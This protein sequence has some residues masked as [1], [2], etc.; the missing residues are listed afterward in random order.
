MDPA[1][2]RAA[3]ALQRLPFSRPWSIERFIADLG[4]QLGRLIKVEELPRAISERGEISGL[5][6]PTDLVDVVLVKQGAAG[7]YR[8]HIICHEIAHVVMA[9]RAD[10]ARLKSYIEQTLSRAAPGITPEMVERLA[11]TPVCLARTDFTHPIERE[12]EW[13][14]TL[15]M[16]H[17]DELRQ[18]L[19]SEPAE[20]RDRELVRRVAALIGWR[21]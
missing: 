16:G 3:V 13:L 14:A 2:N 9:H 19:Y 6:V 4:F 7:K 5:W 20:Q 21:V 10:S 18:E 8:E 17:A 1:Y 11:G 12:A 15:I